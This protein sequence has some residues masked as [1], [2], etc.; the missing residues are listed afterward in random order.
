M[1][2]KGAAHLISLII[3][4]VTVGI[5]AIAV[6]MYMKNSIITTADNNFSSVL[7]QAETAKIF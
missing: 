7:K 4:F 3:G 5:I 1:Y 6:L 2:K